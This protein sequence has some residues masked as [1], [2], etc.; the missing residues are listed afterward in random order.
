MRGKKMAGA[1]M[2]PLPQISNV[3]L[4]QVPVLTDERLLLCAGVRIAFTSRAGGVSEGAY[5]SLNL[6]DHVQDDPACVARNRSRLCDA[7]GA[8]EE[9]LVVPRQVHGCDL[10]EIGSSDAASIERA[11]AAAGEGADG[12][13]VTCAGVPAL[14]CFADCVPVIIVSPTGAFA[15]VHAGWR[16]AVAHIAA[17]AVRALAEADARA[18]VPD[19]TFGMNAYLGPH[20][21][22]ECFECGEE[23]VSRFRAEFGEACVPDARHVDLSTA[24]TRDL[25]DAGMNPERVADAGICTVCARDEYFSY[26]A[27]GGVAGRHGAFAVRGEEVSQ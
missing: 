16:G 13:V 18:G 24:L 4:K 3:N 17:R 1:L 19:T 25:V 15:V 27:Q 23:V 14:L 10:V 7:L 11:R 2:L 21:R 5:T 20:I 8:R 12:L 9:R 22:S 6:G 26:R